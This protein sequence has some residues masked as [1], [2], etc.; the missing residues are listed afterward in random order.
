MTSASTGS[1]A[2][3]FDAFE[4]N[5]IAS[6]YR[7]MLEAEGSEWRAKKRPG[8]ASGAA[9]GRGR[10]RGRGKAKAAGRGGGAA[11]GAGASMSAGHG[12]E[13]GGGAG[14]GGAGVD[15]VD[16]GGS[17]ESN[18][19]DEDE[20]YRNL[21]EFVM[22]LNEES[23]K[24]GGDAASAAAS[25]CRAD[26]SSK[27]IY[28][29]RGK[30]FVAWSRTIEEQDNND[31]PA[32]EVDPHNA[33]ALSVICISNLVVVTVTE[34]PLNCYQI[35]SQG[36][37]HGFHYNPKKF[38]AVVAS[39][40]NPTATAMVFPTGIITVLG[41][42]EFSGAMRTTRHVMDTIGAVTDAFGN[43]IYR[44]LSA[45]TVAMTNIV[46]SLALFFRIDLNRLIE[47]PFVRYEDVEF[48]GGIVDV[49]MAVPQFAGR[50]VKLLAFAT[51]A[52]V[53]TGTKDRG[54][55]FQVYKHVF[56]YLVRCAAKDTF[57][58]V[59]QVSREERL[60]IRPEIRRAM[61]LPHDSC[62]IIRINSRKQMEV[63]ESIHGKL[64]EAEFR[65]AELS[66][67]VA[68]AAAA[69]AAGGRGS[70]ALAVRTPGDVLAAR[71]TARKRGNAEVAGEF[72]GG[73]NAIA[74]STISDKAT[75]QQQ[76][77][78]QREKLRKTLRDGLVRRSG[79][80]EPSHAELD[81]AVRRETAPKHTL[82]LKPEDAYVLVDEI[83]EED[84][85]N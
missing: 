53:I 22:Q 19:I 24:F 66:A 75:Q 41:I 6:Y 37:I 18:V 9:R 77:E 60:R 21:P 45:K 65:R 27:T 28:D 2:L 80:R 10:G 84:T 3:P 58:R 33:D 49:G 1:S 36:T 70:N 34:T 29:V 40:L 30:D 54:E 64:D 44:T 50:R 32:D 14:S 71:K 25:L 55:V 72:A 42:N 23:E 59:V 63:F 46:A 47:L 76:L 62:E 11:A 38:A 67:V 83:V 17:G 43:R 4:Q 20:V 85:G 35:A 81:R 8:A 48:I 73:R 7:D 82:L 26:D 31:I 68:A 78:E 12:A 16:G 39:F 61:T 79:G 51:G 56:P 13:A 74:L 15:G 52:I 69:A 57:G 5:F